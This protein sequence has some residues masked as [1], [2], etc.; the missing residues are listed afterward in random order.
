MSL[1]SSETRTKI[2][3]DLQNAM[4]NYSPSKEDILAILNALKEAFPELEALKGPMSN[5]PDQ[6]TAS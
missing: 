4:R 2:A 3:R 1:G 5:L 6:I